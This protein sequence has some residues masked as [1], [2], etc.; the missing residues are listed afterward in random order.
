MKYKKDVIVDIIG[1]RK[2]G[3]NELDQPSFTQPF[4]YERVKTRR[5]FLTSTKIN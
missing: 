1:Y 4:M 2:Y 5:T 3:H